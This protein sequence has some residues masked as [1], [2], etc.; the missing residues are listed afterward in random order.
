MLITLTLD[1]QAAG[2]VDASDLSHLLRKHPARVQEFTSPVGAIHVFYPEVSATRTTVALLLEVD[3]IHLVR[4]K[5][6][7]G[8]SGALDHYVNDRPY[9]AS[10][11]TSVALGTVFRSAMAGTSESHPELA[12]AAVSVQINVPVVSVGGGEGESLVARLFRPLGWTV[13]QDPIELDEAHPEWGRSRYSGLR[14]SAQ[15]P[16]SQALRQL[17]VLLPVLDDSKHYWVSEDE[18]SKLVRQGQGWLVDHPE[19]PLIMHRYLAHQSSLVDLAE[20][21]LCS[22]V[23]PGTSPAPVR[24]GAEVPTASAVGGEQGAASLRVL[25]VE[26]VVEALRELGA[27]RIVDMGCGPGVLLSRL[28]AVDSF[29]EILGVDVDP[30]ALDRAA[31]RLHLDQASDAQ[32]QRLRLLHGSVVYRDD[33]LRGFDAMVLMEVIEHIDESRL[34]A[35]VDAV[36][37][38][39]QPSAVVLTTPNSEYNSLYPTLEAGKFR[40][41]DHRFEWSRPQLRE[42]AEA[43]A[44][45][46]GYSVEIRP[47]GACDDDHG[48][49]TQMAIFRK[50]HS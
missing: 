8:E 48:P 49:P 27:H 39:A 20:E 25:R 6:F 26:A 28:D 47:I 37:G 41:A 19:R 13:V 32:R 31:S 45:T 5:R 34:P 42:W 1:G 33:R 12:A 43:T 15:M 24:S 14:L 11:L 10:S 40:H 18:V 2:N 46:H 50:V 30:R 38:A 21:E 36:F 22:A 3:P 7:R 4:S 17:Y 35:C 44:A 9:A 16:V 29:T 23:G